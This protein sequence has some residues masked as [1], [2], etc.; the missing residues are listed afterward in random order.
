M[1]REIILTKKFRFEAAH[2]LTSYHG[3]CEKLHGHSYILEISIIGTPDTEGMVIDFAVL[4]KI[5][6]EHIIDKLD[7]TY[8]NDVFTFNPTVENMLLWMADELS[9]LLKS[10]TRRLYKIVI[11]ETD[12]NKSEI[13]LG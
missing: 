3:Q 8:L 6:K 13:I 5:V 7:H 4:K 10:D 1:S 12:N 2:N 9:P 11:W